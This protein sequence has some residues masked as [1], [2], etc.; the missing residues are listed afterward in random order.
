MSSGKNNSWTC[1]RHSPLYN[2][3][4]KV[5][6]IILSSGFGVSPI[7]TINEIPTIP[8]ALCWASDMLWY[9]SLLKPYNWICVEGKGRLDKCVHKF[10]WEGDVWQCFSTY[11]SWKTSVFVA[12]IEDYWN[13]VV[14]KSLFEG[15]QL[16]WQKW[17]SKWLFRE[18]HNFFVSGWLVAEN[19]FF[20]FTLLSTMKPKVLFRTSSRHL[21]SFL[22]KLFFKNISKYLTNACCVGRHSKTPLA[23]DE[24]HTLARDTSG[25]ETYILKIFRL[26]FFISA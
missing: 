12:R 15:V 13:F 7:C 16:F 25:G 5:L 10:F 24:V 17:L 2:T 21:P 26:C 20:L 1:L 8:C 22:Y 4:L 6:V 14:K 18:F 9:S 19:I 23:H 3:L 11:V